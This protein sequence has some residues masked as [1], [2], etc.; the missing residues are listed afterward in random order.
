MVLN[1]GVLDKLDLLLVVIL[2]MLL[3]TDVIANLHLFLNQV[4]GLDEA[5]DE[6]V[7]LLTF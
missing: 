7:S 5:A 3:V 4:F 2:G 6:V 1:L